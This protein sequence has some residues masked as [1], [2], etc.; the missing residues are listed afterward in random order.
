V[1]LE[2]FYGGSWEAIVRYDNAHGFCHRDTLQSDGSQDKTRVFVGDLNDTFT[3]AV[4]E[5]RPIG[6]RIAPATLGRFSHDRSHGVHAKAVRADG[7]VREGMSSRIPRSMTF[8]LTARSSTSKSRES[9]SLASTA[10][11]SR[12]NSTAR[13]AFRSS[14]CASKGWLHLRSLVS[15][16]PS[17]NRWLHGPDPIAPPSLQ[18][19][20]DR[21]RGGE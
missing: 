9:G 5:L 18:L 8:C 14:W 11:S 21:D 7:G 13:K 6:K 2:I 3:Y 16:I 10:E 1:Q 15:S 17:S 12:R 4:E 20:F 19:F